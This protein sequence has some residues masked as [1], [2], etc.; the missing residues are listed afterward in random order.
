MTK[1]GYAKDTGRFVY[2]VQCR[3][4]GMHQESNIHTDK[5]AASQ[6]GSR[7]PL[8]MPSAVVLLVLWGLKVM[9][10]ITW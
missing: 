8:S 2:S 6:P 4:G 5:M 7:D 9:H 1:P 10:A 3:L